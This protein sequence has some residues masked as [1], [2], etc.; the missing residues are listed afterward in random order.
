MI[1]LPLAS[2][3]RRAVAFGIDLAV[4]LLPSL[5]V[6]VAAAAL[7]LH[8]SD[9]QAVAGIT[10]LMRGRALHA[11]ARNE[12]FQAVVPTENSIPVEN[13]ALATRRCQRHEPC[14]TC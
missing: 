9:P 4:L 11:T 2:P 8:F 12:A 6:A 1:G 14:I 5:A 7:S 13:V 3:L 10:S